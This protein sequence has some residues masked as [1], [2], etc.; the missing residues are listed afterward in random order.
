MGDELT[1]FTRRILPIDKENNTV[2]FDGFKIPVNKRIGV[3][4]VA[5]EGN[6]VNNGTPDAHGGNMDNDK[7]T[8]GATLYLNAFNEEGLFGLSDVYGAMGA[9]EV[10][11]S[12]LEVESRVT[13]KPE[14]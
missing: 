14:V 12:N 6:A 11:V 3:I 1:E 8:E 13:V 10:S 7:I 9:G 4:G 5:P 2:D